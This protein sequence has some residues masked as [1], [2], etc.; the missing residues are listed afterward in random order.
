MKGKTFIGFHS[1]QCSIKTKIANFNVLDSEI[2][3]SINK[4]YSSLSKNYEPTPVNDGS[5]FNTHSNLTENE[6]GSYFPQ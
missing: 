4:D 1:V 2:L 5:Q 6:R 3:K